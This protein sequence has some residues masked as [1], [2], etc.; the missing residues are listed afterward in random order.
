[1]PPQME[2][3]LQFCNSLITWAFSAMVLDNS[4]LKIIIKLKCLYRIQSLYNL[5]QESLEQNIVFP[6][7]S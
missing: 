3:V 6:F 7:L 5:F 1:M 2:G 4:E